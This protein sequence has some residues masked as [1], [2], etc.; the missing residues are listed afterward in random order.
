MA[1]EHALAN[2]INPNTASDLLL[3]LPHGFNILRTRASSEPVSAMA[4]ASGEGET[5]L[6][7]SHKTLA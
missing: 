7:K 4:G 5:C 6:A 2:P 1:S 3:I